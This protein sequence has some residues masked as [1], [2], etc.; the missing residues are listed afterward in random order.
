[1]RW[2][3]EKG[4]PWNLAADFI[5]TNNSTS[6]SVLQYNAYRLSR[7]SNGFHFEKIK[8]T[9][10]LIISQPGIYHLDEFVFSIHP[11]TGE[12]IKMTDDPNEEFISSTVVHFPLYVRPVAAGDS[13]QPL[14]MQGRNKKLQD[15]LVDRKL[16][17]HEKIKVKLLVNAHHILWVIG[18]QLDDR[19]KINTKDE[20]AYQV[21]YRLT[22]SF[23]KKSKDNNE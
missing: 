13:F 4:I 16:D 6:G 20:A 3:E 5:G 8:E 17:M 12:D 22:S 15:L 14:G 9:E 1:L 18:I 21:S 23:L 7:S 2:L 19:A 10:Q 11:V